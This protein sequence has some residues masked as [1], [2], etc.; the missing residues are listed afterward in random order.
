MSRV[1]DL[2]GRFV[3]GTGGQLWR[4]R[5]PNGNIIAEL[6]STTPTAGPLGYK[7]IPSS[8][9]HVYTGLRVL[10]TNSTW[11]GTTFQCIAYTLANRCEQN[12]SAKRVT[13][14]VGGKCRMCLS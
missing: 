5:S 12:D 3:N 8:D 11:N 14:Q 1:K 7:F 13:L 4:I 10:D 2:H 6:Y 9:E